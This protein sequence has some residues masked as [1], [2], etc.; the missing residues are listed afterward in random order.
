MLTFAAA[1][2]AITMKLAARP[3]LRRFGF[4]ACCWPTPC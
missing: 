1:L 3:I 4:D 2:G